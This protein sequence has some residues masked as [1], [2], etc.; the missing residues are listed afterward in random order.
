MRAILQAILPKA[1]QRMQLANADFARTKMPM[2]PLCQRGDGRVITRQRINPPLKADC[3]Q[4]RFT[5][6]ADGIFALMRQRQQVRQ[7]AAQI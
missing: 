5:W 1:N 4:H 7:Q 2:Q 6:D 3:S